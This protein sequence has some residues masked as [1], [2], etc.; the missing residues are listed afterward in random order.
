MIKIC[1]VCK[2][3]FEATR[4]DKKFCSPECMKKMNIEYSR[5]YREAHHEHGPYQKNCAVCGK[6]FETNRTDKKF[7]SRECY[8]KNNLERV[9]KRMGKSPKADGI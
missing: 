8:E 4:P 7:C 2:K 6:E 3:E 1:A 9:R 5:K